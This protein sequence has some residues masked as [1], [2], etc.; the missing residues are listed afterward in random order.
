MVWSRWGLV[1][2][3]Q[4]KLLHKKP[5]DALL[6]DIF[7]EHSDVQGTR[8]EMV[9]TLLKDATRVDFLD[10]AQLILRDVY[11][12]EVRQGTLS[13]LAMPKQR[14]LWSGDWRVRTSSV[15]HCFEQVGR[16]QTHVNITALRQVQRRQVVGELRAERVPRHHGPAQ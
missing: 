9:K 2:S 7:G 13:M 14:T 6:G 1:S 8:R 10:E 15:V 16:R 4:R 5:C 3:I 12:K 11:L